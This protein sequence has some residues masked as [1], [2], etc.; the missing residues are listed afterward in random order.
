MSRLRR[1][2]DRD[3]ILFVTTNLLLTV[4]PFDEN[5][6]DTILH[7]L[8]SIRDKQNMAIAAYAVM[9]DHV[10]LILAPDATGLARFMHGFKRTSQLAISQ[11]RGTGGPI[12]QRR[13]FDN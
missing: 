9:P 1:L 8:S 5:E 3:R 10:H 11:S 4:R 13:Y 6:R 2:E 7:V 12:W